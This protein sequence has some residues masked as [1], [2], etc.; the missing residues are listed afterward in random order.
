MVKKKYQ[1]F[2]LIVM[3][4]SALI[5]P[6]KTY[7]QT[8]ISIKTAEKELI[9]GNYDK[10]LAIWQILAK[11][12]NLIAVNNLG[13]MYEKGYGLVRNEKKAV[14]LYK[15]AAEGGVSVAQFNYGEALYLGK[16]INKNKIEAT[17]WLLLALNR[18]SKD[19]LYLLKEVNKTLSYEDKTEAK[20]RFMEW[21]KNFENRSE[22]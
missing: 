7:S 8:T 11:Q 3:F 21:T 4:T 10:S 1:I 9:D 17:K 6:Y 15:K 12:G 18:G 16:G 20:I 5:L 13:F 19:A 14:H 2:I 22:N